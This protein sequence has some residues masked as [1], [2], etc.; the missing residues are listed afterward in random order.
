MLSDRQGSATGIQGTIYPLPVVL[1]SKASTSSLISEAVQ[2]V[3]LY[4][5][6]SQ[7]LEQIKGPG[8]SMALENLLP[9]GRYC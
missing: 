5:V 1:I 2:S 7:R 8:V 9:R 6:R 3:L 4:K